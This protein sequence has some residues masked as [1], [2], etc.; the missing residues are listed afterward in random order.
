MNATFLGFVNRMCMY[1]NE[2]I[3]MLSN[4]LSI[5]IIQ[6]YI[7]VYIYMCVYVY[8]NSF[9]LITHEKINEKNCGCYNAN[10]FTQ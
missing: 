9:Q 7:H 4:V 1:V 5:L 8:K 6:L 3:L 2:Q 10:H